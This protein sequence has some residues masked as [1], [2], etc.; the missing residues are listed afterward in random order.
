MS[1]TI[2]DYKARGSAFIDQFENY[3][4]TMTDYG[5]QRASAVQLE[6]QNEST[7]NNLPN[8]QQETLQNIMQYTITDTNLTSWYI[9]PDLEQEKYIRILGTKDVGTTQIT[10]SATGDNCL[11]LPGRSNNLCSNPEVIT[12]NFFTNTIQIPVTL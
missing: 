11:I 2:P 7:I 9:D 1:I 5:K 10:I 4:D 3:G 8:N 6:Q 12:D